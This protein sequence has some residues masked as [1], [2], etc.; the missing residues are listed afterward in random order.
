M[1][2]ITY[3][4]KCV[5][6]SSSA[7]PL[8]FTNWICSWCNTHWTIDEIDWER[9]KKKFIRIAN[10]YKS[11]DETNYDC[12]IP[13]S[14]WKDSY[15][16]V[17]IIK[18]VCWLNPLLITYN[19]NN[20]TDTGLKNLYNMRKA[21]GVDH[22]FYTPNIDTLKKMNRMWMQM[23]WDMNWHGHS[24]IFTYPIKMA[25]QSKVPLMIW[26]EHWFMD[27]WWMHSYNDFVEFTYRYRHEHSLRWY[28]WDDFLEN[29]EKYWEELK[30]QDLIT[31][32]YPS[33]KEIEDI[34]VRW[35]YISNYFKWDANTHGPLMM[36][37]YWFIEY[38]HEFERTYRKM[39]NL[40]DMHE[41]WI[42]DYMKFVKF[43]YWRATDHVSKDIRSWIMTRDKWIEI[44]K[45]MDHIK[46]KD[47]YRWLDY[48]WWTEE[49]FNKIAD[50]FRDPR[51]WWIE[52]WKWYKNN[53]WWDNSSYWKV[54]LPKNLHDKYKK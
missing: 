20:Y 23:M 27:L 18:N 43:W 8:E 25:V 46:S 29:A 1:K 22:I 30:K 49:K 42:H 44:I 9:R 28:E 21:F 36:E 54:Y 45:K 4:K 7:V 35:I 50:T 17:H 33:D 40:D 48:V 16:Q 24:W 51:V 10:E 38:E 41:N 47:L 15:F 12:I 52:N 53:I 11:K 31:W 37:K 6:T 32:M 26:G 3:C 13:V 34:W 2:N 19:S 5:N 39:S 14:W